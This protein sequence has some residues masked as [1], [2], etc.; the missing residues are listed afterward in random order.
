M[1]LTATDVAALESSLNHWNTIAYLATALVF[2][3]VAGESVEEFADFP[4]NARRK[5]R[6][7]KICALVL[8]LGLAGELISLIRSSEL[9]GKIDAVLTEQAAQ[10]GREAAQANG[11]MNIAIQQQKAL[12]AETEGA[13]LKQ[14]Q[15]RQQNLRLQSEVEKERTARRRIEERMAPRTMSATQCA[16]VSNS[17]LT[18]QGAR[19]AVGSPPDDPESTEFAQQIITCL[20]AAKLNVESLVGRQMSSGSAQNLWIQFDPER[21]TLVRAIARALVEA[22][23]VRG[24][25]SIQGDGQKG[26]LSIIIRKKP[27]TA[28]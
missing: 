3:G 27:L 24:D 10:A 14:E 15:L 19:V 2:A 26:S 6:V 21:I 4:K 8:I 23:V 17:L 11:Q 12:E 9:S 5:G 13:R 25:V 16:H 18:F 7:R 28:Q 22:N 20:Q 1:A